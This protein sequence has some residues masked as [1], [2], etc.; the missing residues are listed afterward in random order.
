M[1]DLAAVAIPLEVVAALAEDREEPAPD[2][3]PLLQQPLPLLRV[4]EVRPESPLP[5]VRPPKVKV[6]VLRVPAGGE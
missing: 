3:W 1:Y 5:H 2:A 6:R 4:P